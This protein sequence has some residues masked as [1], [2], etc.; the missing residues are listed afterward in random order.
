MKATATKPAE[1]VC[2]HR[3]AA[4]LYDCDQPVGKPG[5]TWC[6]AHVKAHAEAKRS[7]AKKAAPKPAAKPKAVTAKRPPRGK[8]VP[9]ATDAAPLD[10]MERELEAVA[11]MKERDASK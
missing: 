2:R 1:G 9:L 4:K 7:A 5:W 6:A 10:P 8:V 11:A 3:N